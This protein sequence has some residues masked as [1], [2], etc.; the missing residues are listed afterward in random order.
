VLASAGVVLQASPD[1]RIRA[2]PRRALTDELRR[3]IR[4]QRDELLTVLELQVVFRRYADRH[5]FT[6]KDR[7]QDFPLMLADPAGWLSYLRQEL[8]E[9][10]F[11][12]P[13]TQCRPNDKHVPVVV[14]NA[15]PA[16]PGERFRVKAVRD[17]VGNGPELRL[18]RRCAFR[19]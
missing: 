15:L 16:D 2:E 18:P 10:T 8:T 17:A 1:G 3:L 13:H 11:R 6:A 4:Q 19:S 14:A 7:E 12:M 5:G 9:A